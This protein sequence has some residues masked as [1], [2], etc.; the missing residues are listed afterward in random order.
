MPLTRMMTPAN[1]THP[2]H[3]VEVAAEDV[4]VAVAGEDA[5]VVLAECAELAV[6]MSGLPSVECA[7]PDRVVGA[8][9][10]PSRL[11]FHQ[12]CCSLRTSISSPCADDD[13]DPS[14]RTFQAKPVVDLSRERKHV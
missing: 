10:L 2:V 12:T 9:V 14:N 3:P 4:P 13:R 7:G 5:P 8:V 6:L 1:V 11:Y